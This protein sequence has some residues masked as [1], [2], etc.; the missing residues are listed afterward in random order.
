MIPLQN[1][2]VPALVADLRAIAHEIRELKR[3]LRTSWLRP[4]A[5]EQRALARL[6]GR[7]TELCAL[8]AFARGKLHLQKAPR[9]AGDDWNAVVYHQRVAERLAPSYSRV[10]ETCA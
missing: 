1:I 8:R 4:M 9:G 5:D 10:L 3:Q 7:A 2:H 6:G